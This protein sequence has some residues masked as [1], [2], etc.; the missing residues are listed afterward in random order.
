MAWK[1][2][3]AALALLGVA[4]C[5]ET[6]HEAAA[7]RSDTRAL[8]TAAVALTSFAPPPVGTVSV[9]PGALRPA[10]GGL[11]FTACPTEEVCGL[12]ASDGTVA[13]TRR[14]MP[15][16]RTGLKRAPYGLRTVGTRALF[17]SDD[18]T[19]PCEQPLNVSYCQLWASDGTEAGTQRL[20]TFNTTGVRPIVSATRVIGDHYLFQASDGEGRFGLWSSDGSA[21]GTRRLWAGADDYGPGRIGEASGHILF[22]GGDAEHGRELWVSD[23]S[24]EGTLLLADLVPGTGSSD[25]GFVAEARGLQFFSA[26]DAAHGVELWRT[27][28]TPEGTVLVADIRP[29]ADSALDWYAPNVQAVAFRDAL[30]FVADDGVHGPELWR[31]DGTASGTVLV[32]DLRPGA[33]GADITYLTAAGE[34]LYFFADDGTSGPA[35]W[36]SDATPEGTQQVKPLR[37]AGP[38][39]E[40]GR[41]VSPPLALEQEGLLLFTAEDP[42]L[43]VELWRSNGTATGT[44]PVQDLVPGAASSWPDE[45]VRVADRVFF[46]AVDGAQARQLWTLPV[47]LLADFA[48]PALRCPADLAVEQGPASDTVVSYAPAESA[49]AVS[50]VYSRPSGTSFPVGSTPVE[51][52]ASDAAGNSARCSFTVTVRA[53]VVES[54]GEGCEASSGGASML[55]VVLLGLLRRRRRA[56]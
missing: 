34:T 52:S 24:A 21:E 36:R 3:L 8:G 33:Q 9:S 44:L 30:L 7:V 39:P 22:A 19:A 43:G 10:W 27:D 31:T 2:K 35:L 26:K 50:L 41:I 12:W 6:E 55:G 11:A 28:G 51:V 15:A 54:A 5:S 20:T 17:M 32:K 25:P 16:G 18:G 40:I 46:V 49:E 47:S 45:L 23:G 37:K 14:V 38:Q 42:A 13:G 1:Q 56:V 29:G 48:P 53:R 4:G